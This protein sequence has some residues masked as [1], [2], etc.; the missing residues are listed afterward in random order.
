MF[1][2]QDLLTLR[3]GTPRLSFK[4]ILSDLIVVDIAALDG[5]GLVVLPC[6]HGSAVIATAI[7]LN[8]GLIILVDLN[9]D[10]ET[11]AIVVITR[12]LA[13]SGRARNQKYSSQNKV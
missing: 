11:G 1:Y 2:S 8:M 4:A 10:I 7:L 6:L 13:V 9:I 5:L 12:G 3:W